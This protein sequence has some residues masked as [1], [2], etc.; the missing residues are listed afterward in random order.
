MMLTLSGC[1]SDAALKQ[2][3]TTQGLADA[4]ITLPTYPEDCRQMEAHAPLV[5][6]SEVRSVL[7]RERA[8]LGRQNDRTQRCA[9][10]YDDLKAGV[11]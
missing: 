1:A 11:Q 4:R 9:N 10:F 8:A 5:V 3:A 2:A 7:K 6:G